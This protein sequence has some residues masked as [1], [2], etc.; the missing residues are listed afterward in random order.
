LN[1]NKTNTPATHVTN[2]IMDVEKKQSRSC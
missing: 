1:D 2:I